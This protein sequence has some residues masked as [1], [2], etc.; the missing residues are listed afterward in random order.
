[1]TSITLLSPKKYS[2][3]SREE[4]SIIASMYDHG[5]LASSIAEELGRSPSTI[6]RELKRNQVSGMYVSKKADMKCYQRRYWVT[7]PPTKL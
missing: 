7:K 4:R 2:Q 6:T 1:M 3:L 5:S